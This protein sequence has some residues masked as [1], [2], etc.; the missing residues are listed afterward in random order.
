MR[1]GSTRN[2]GTELRLHEMDQRLRAYA[3]AASAAGV[4]MLALAQPA[5]AQVVYTPANVSITDGDLFLDL[6]CGSKVQFWFADT[7]EASSYGYFREFAVNGSVGA[8]V[9][10]DAHGPVALPRGSVIGSSRTFKNVHRGEQVM[11]QA[12]TTGYGSSG[13]DGNW[14]NGKQ[15]YLGLKF[16]IQG[17][18]HYGWASL[19]VK[20]SI[21]QHHGLH[22]DATLLGYAYE[23]TPNQSIQAG[24]T[25]DADAANPDA[26]SPEAGTLGALARGAASLGHCPDIEPHLSAGRKSHKR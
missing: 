15:A 7:G 3:L 6:N 16:N 14:A 26:F 9:M 2:R 12:F 10:V 5:H 8:S 1:H 18:V 11:A 22:V 23:S 13:V 21:D 20:P 24:Q 25:R 17:E 19:Q 4:G